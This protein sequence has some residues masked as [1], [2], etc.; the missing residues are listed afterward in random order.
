MP[1][2]SDYME[3]TGE[4]IY[5]I[6]VANLIIFVNKQ[7]GLETDGDIERASKDYYGN[8]V[9]TDRVVSAL[10]NLVRNVMTDEQRDKIIYDAHNEN[11][12]QLASWWEKHQEEDRKHEEE[13]RIKAKQKELFESAMSKLTDEER[14]LIFHPDFGQRGF[15]NN[16][17]INS[18]KV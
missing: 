16:T 7:L 13:D 15:L 9:T 8:G 3:K 10:C 6:K 14:K 1:C 12:R 11:S 5:R 17:D 4:E 18:F 2:R